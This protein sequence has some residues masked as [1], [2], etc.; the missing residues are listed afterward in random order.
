MPVTVM[1]QYPRN[2]SAPDKSHLCAFF[3][4]G[5]GGYIIYQFWKMSNDANKLLVNKILHTSQM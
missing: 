4:L 1:C 5:M 3:L 2:K